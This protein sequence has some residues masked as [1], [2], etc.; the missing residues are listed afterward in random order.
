LWSLLERILTLPQQSF[1]ER[2]SALVHASLW[3][4]RMD[5]S[6]AASQAHGTHTN[7]DDLLV[8]DASAVVRHLLDTSGDIHVIADNTGTEL[9]MDLVL[10]DALLADKANKVI[11]HLKMH[12]TFVSDATAPDVLTLI[13]TISSYAQNDEASTFGGRLYQ[14]FEVGRLRLAQD[15]YWNS[16]RLLW[17]MPP[18]LADVFR[19][20]AL[21]IIKGDANYRRM[22]G[23]LPWDPETPFAA[24]TDYFPAPLLALR[25]LKSDLIVGLPAGL[26][27]RLDLTDSQWR[28][29]GRRGLIQFRS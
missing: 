21:V 22:V 19:R 10:A 25:T 7:D 3:G 23:D 12:P 1:E 14:A 4:N 18:H 11:I 13:D 5:L 17:D 15:F 2:L 29:N 28:T 8:N 9:A 27:G 20:A 24:V 26:T 16:A 6:Y